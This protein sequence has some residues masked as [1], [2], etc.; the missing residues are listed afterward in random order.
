MQL[1]GKGSLVASSLAAIGVG[2]RR[3]RY[4]GERSDPDGATSAPLHWVDATVPGIGFPQALP[5]AA[6]LY[7]GYTVR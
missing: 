2:T 5:G 1:T 7:A 3:R 4:V 6:G